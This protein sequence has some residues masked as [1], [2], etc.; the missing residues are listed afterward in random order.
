MKEG[1]REKVNAAR[2]FND[3]GT[4]K[5]KDILVIICFFLIQIKKILL[6]GDG[7]EQH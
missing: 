4:F 3:F 6:S 5:D 1:T 7:M 2:L